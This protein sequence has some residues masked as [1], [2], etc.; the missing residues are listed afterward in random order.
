MAELSWTRKDQRIRS[1]LKG[2]IRQA[3]Q[4]LEEWEEG[5]TNQQVEDDVADFATDLE[6]Y[7]KKRVSRAIRHSR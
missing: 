4:I 3:E 2:I 6:D 7:W 1:S 5:G